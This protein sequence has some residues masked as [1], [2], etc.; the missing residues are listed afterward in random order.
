MISIADA[1]NQLPALIHQAEAGEPVFIRFAPRFGVAHR[2]EL[3]HRE[4]LA[5]AAR[6]LLLEQHGRAKVE[7][8]QSSDDQ[9]DGGRQHQRYSCEDDVEGPLHADVRT[10]HQRFLTTEFSASA[11]RSNW[12]G[13]RAEPLGSDTPVANRRSEVP[14][15]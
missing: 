3:Q 4:N 13:V 1:K 7:A 2:A 10:P 9:L 12:A 8:H 6:S 5:V 14:L 11:T 15:R